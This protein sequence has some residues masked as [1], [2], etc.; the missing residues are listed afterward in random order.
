MNNKL[1]KIYFVATW[2]L[3]RFYTKCTH[4][5]RFVILE[6]KIFISNFH[7]HFSLSLFEFFTEALSITNFI[8]AFF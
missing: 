2:F 5:V 6:A 4:R 8:T 1:A 7:Q 3:Y